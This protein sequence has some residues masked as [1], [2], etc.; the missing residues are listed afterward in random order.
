MGSWKLPLVKLQMFGKNF[1]GKSAAEHIQLYIPFNENPFRICNFYLFT[2]HNFVYN[3]FVVRSF[4]TAANACNKRWHEWQ[5][6][7]NIGPSCR[8]CSRSFSVYLAQRGNLLH[9]YLFIAI[10]IQNCIPFPRSIQSAIVYNCTNAVHILWCGSLL[11]DSCSMRRCFTVVVEENAFLCS[12]RINTDEKP[13]K[14]GYAFS[15]FRRHH[16]K[17]TIRQNV[18]VC[19]VANLPW[20]EFEC[21]NFA[22]LQSVELLQT[23]QTQTRR[24]R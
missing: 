3:F 2:I 10:V 7:C 23:N 12:N 22:N 13:R 20:L 8:Q 5:E 19:S 24:A 16:W 11:D 6:K 21:M 9:I 15:L 17:M 18:C 1:P 14:V 4:I